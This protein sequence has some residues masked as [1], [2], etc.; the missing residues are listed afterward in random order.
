MIGNA[1]TKDEFGFMEDESARSARVNNYV[2]VST[3][4]KSVSPVLI[5]AINYKAAKFKVVSEIALTIGEGDGKGKVR[6]DKCKEEEGK[7]V[8]VEKHIRRLETEVK[9]K[10]AQLKKMKNS[11]NELQVQ[12]KALEEEHEQKCKE[13]VQHEKHIRELNDIIHKQKHFHNCSRNH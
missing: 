7:C 11:N 13:I 3:N 12:N 5:Q 6:C 8:E 9:R 1:Q 4:Y 10:R 2:N